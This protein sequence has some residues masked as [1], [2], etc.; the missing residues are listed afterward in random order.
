MLEF[1]RIEAVSY[2]MKT[3]EL[4]RQLGVHPVTVVRWAKKKQIPGAKSTKGDRWYFPASKEFSGWLA[5]ELD[6]KAKLQKDE[7]MRAKRCRKEEL[8]ELRHREQVIQESIRVVKHPFPT[9]GG[10]NRTAILEASLN[11]KEKALRSVFADCSGWMMDAYKALGWVYLVK[12]R[13]ELRASLLAS[14]APLE[15]AAKEIRG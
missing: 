11:A 15:A 4:A 1:V 10:E 2:C 8:L 6:A 7:E 5:S 3:S 14:L 9:G 12:Q 13:P